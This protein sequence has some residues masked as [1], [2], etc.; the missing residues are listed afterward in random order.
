M[1]GAGRAEYGKHVIQKLALQL[2]AE[3][4]KGFDFGSLYKFLQFYKKFPILDSLSPKSGG[5]L[6][7]THYRKLLQV[8]NKDALAWYINEAATWLKL[9][10]ALRPG[11][12]V[13]MW[14]MSPELADKVSQADCRQIHRL[15]TMSAASAAECGVWYNGRR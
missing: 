1:K 12:N 14:Q 6:S 2:T 8:E 15:Q 10:S 7:W 4:G 9:K 5:L 3:Y 13:G 11:G